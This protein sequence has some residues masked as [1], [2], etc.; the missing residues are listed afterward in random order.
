MFALFFSKGLYSVSCFPFLCIYCASKRELFFI[1][2]KQTICIYIPWAFFEQSHPKR[3][4]DEGARNYSWV[5]ILWYQ[6]WSLEKSL[7]GALPHTH[8]RILH[9]MLTHFTNLDGCEQKRWNSCSMWKNKGLRSLQVETGRVVWD[10]TLESSRKP[11]LKAKG[12]FFA[13]EW[14]FLG[15]K[16]HFLSSICKGQTYNIFKVAFPKPLTAS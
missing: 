2:K 11:N 8:G 10:H 7:Y 14:S 9:Y 15:K 3:L 4:R 13:L 5:L 1:I 6:Q 12:P 16:M